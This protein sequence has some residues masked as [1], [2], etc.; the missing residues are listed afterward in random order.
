VA[1][2]LSGQLLATKIVACTLREL[3]EEVLACAEAGIAGFVAADSSGEDL[4]A[5]VRH[6]MRDELHCSPQMAGLLFRRVR[7]LVTHRPHSV[8][9][10][11]LTRRERQ[12]LELLEQGMSNKEIGRALNISDTTVKTHVHYV[13]EKLQVHRRGEAAAWLRA[14]RN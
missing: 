8:L 9:P 1:K 13:I 6:A 11:T 10:V 7:A 5:A 12:V 2:V 4:V 3:D 14:S